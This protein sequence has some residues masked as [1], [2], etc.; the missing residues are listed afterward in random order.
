MTLELGFVP[1][2]FVE[3]AVAPWLMG[4]GLEAGKD[5]AEALGAASPSKPLSEAEEGG[6]WSTP[7]EQRTKSNSDNSPSLVMSSESLTAHLLII[8]SKHGATGSVQNISV[9][10]GRCLSKQQL[11]N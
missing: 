9:S 10:T 1:G 5:S 4:T 2:P 3:G 7:D 8:P 6:T 11:L